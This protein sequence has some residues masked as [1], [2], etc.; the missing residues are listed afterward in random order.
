L[1]SGLVF[2][3]ISIFQVVRLSGRASVTTC[4]IPFLSLIRFAVQ[5]AVSLKI[6]LFFLEFHHLVNS[7]SHHF[8][9]SVGSLISNFSMRFQSDK[10]VFTH[11]YLFISKKN[12]YGFF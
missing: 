8:D 5:K 10:Y 7:P 9:P 1:V 6:H 11:K 3:N 12:A 2:A 4:I